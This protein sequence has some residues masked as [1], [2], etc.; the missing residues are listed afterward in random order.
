MDSGLYRCVSGEAKRVQ[1]GRVLG[2]GSH[3]LGTRGYR[4]V[5]SAAVGY[6]RTTSPCRNSGTQLPVTRANRLQPVHGPGS[7]RSEAEVRGRRAPG[8]A[9]AVCRKPCPVGPVQVSHTGPEPKT[10]PHSRFGC[11]AEKSSDPKNVQ[12]S[13]FQL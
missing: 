4:P 9:L 5:P 3:P 2:S 8:R 10:H 13:T 1:V 12:A 7:E 6:H 11:A